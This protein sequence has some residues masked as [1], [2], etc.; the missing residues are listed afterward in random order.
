[1]LVLSPMI[2][3]W[4]ADFTIT[5]PPG[6][7]LKAVF[8]SENLSEIS[9]I[10]SQQEPISLRCGAP[11]GVKTCAAFKDGAEVARATDVV[12]NGWNHG[13]ATFPSSFTYQKISW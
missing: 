6:T 12:F 9:K 7:D 8:S 1:M 4:A 3:A 13:Y 5:L 11:K 2:T 10:P